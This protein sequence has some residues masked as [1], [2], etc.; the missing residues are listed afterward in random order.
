MSGLVFW[1]KPGENYVRVGEY[2][3]SRLLDSSSCGGE[4]YGFSWLRDRIA[5]VKRHGRVEQVNALELSEVGSRG[6]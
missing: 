6:Q 4:A 2:K 3:G 1:Q 5:D